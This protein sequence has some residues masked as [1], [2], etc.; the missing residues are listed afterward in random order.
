MDLLKPCIRALKWAFK[1]SFLNLAFMLVPFNNMGPLK[2]MVHFLTGIGGDF[3]MVNLSEYDR[4][5]LSGDEGKAKQLAMQVMVR[6]AEVSGVDRLVD[7]SMAHVNSCFY[8]GQVGVDFAEFLLKEG[9]TVA[10]PTL[11]NVG[12]IDLLHPD[13]RPE[14]SNQEAVQGARKL[15]AIY[16]KLGCEV[17]W[18]CAPYQL[19]ERPGLGDQI[20]GSESNAVSFYN[21]VLGAR[22]NKYGDFLDICAAVTGRAP[23]AGLH[24]DECRRGEVLFRVGGVPAKLREEDIFYHV[25]GIILGR[26][27]GT[28]IPVIEGL[29]QSVNEDQLKAVS[30]AGAASGSVSLFHAIGITPEAASYD[31]AF[32]GGEPVR[33]VDVTAEM[34]TTAR[35]MLS[36]ANSG[37]LA[38][39][40][41]GTPHFSLTE[42]AK[43][44]ALIRGRKV[45]SKV[46][47]FI[48]TSRF[49]L[50]D[51]EKQGWL[52][53]LEDAGVRMVVD[54]CTY[55]TP[56]VNG[57][58]GR[59]MTNSGKWAYYAPGMLDV[60]VVFGSMEECVES[61]VQ[62]TVW[63]DE[64]LWDSEFWGGE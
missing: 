10:V 42:F 30:A 31:D 13:L 54:T 9:G 24:R 6:A 49:I 32:Q 37:A 16:E 25:L 22:T 21:S 4:R 62:G 3:I 23:N 53:E 11:T 5:L 7:V 15:M 1:A 36:H 46:N 26:E 18:T 58:E 20:V 48:S 43:L 34:L 33:V 44:M 38:A 40:C 12:L 28:S 27:S 35:D 50:A 52:S 63:R 2:M 55:F 57:V 47:F 64:R 61:A 51:V 14:K 59:V 60:S 41:L 17:V 29:P 56:V 39:V 8:S 45:N 19:K